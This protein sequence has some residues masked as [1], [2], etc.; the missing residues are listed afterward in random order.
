MVHSADSP[1]REPQKHA[2]RRRGRVLGTA[3]ALAVTAGAVSAGYAAFA[4]PEGRAP[5]AAPPRVRG[6]LVDFT[7][8]GG[9]LT[10]DTATL[11]ITGRTEDGAGVPVSD[12]AGGDLGEPGRVE[13]KG[14][15]DAWSA[16]WA[17]PKGLGVT[18]TGDGGRLRM[19]VRAQDGTTLDWPVS[20][21]G[22]GT[23]GRGAA[24]QVPRGEGLSV[25]VADPFWNSPDAGLAGTEAELATGS[26]TLPLWGYTTGG[27]GVSYLVPESVGTSLAFA[28]AGGRL[29][30]TARHEFSRREDTLDYTVTF[31]LTAASPV[32][33]AAD[34]RR[35]LREHGQS[36]TLKEKIAANPEVG[37]LLGAHHAYLWGGARSPEA[38]RRLRELGSTRAWLGYDADGS[39]MSAEAVAA[40]KR[41]GYVVGPYDTYANGQDPATADT[42]AAVWPGGV[43]PGHCVRTWKGDIKKGFGNRGC[44]LSSEAFARTEATGH[45]LAD[46]ARAVTGN[47]ANSVFLDV[48]A[49]GELF[50]DF[51]PDHPMTKKQDRANRMARMRTLADRYRFVLGSESAVSWSAPVL[52]FSHGS[53]TPAND[54]LWPFQKQAAWGAYHPQGAPGFFFRP[55]E[56]PAALA[57]SLYDPAYRVPLYQTA[58]HDSLISTERWE[59]PYDKFPAQKTDRALM[60]LLYNTPLNFVL[61]DGN[62]ES[63]GREMARLQRAFA[64]LHRAAGTEPM[65]DFRRLTPDRLVQRTVFGD[66]TLTVTANFGTAPYHGLP[67]GCADARLK[68]DPA[69][70]RLCPSGAGNQ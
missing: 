41:Q 12:A 27:H 45:H 61:G 20:G 18:A 28:S 36:R 63:T 13:V 9:T 46:R 58:L 51:S 33:P 19:T 31:A 30:A 60:S 17:Y 42:P 53:Q 49:A 70:R 29:H 66:G 24:L 14:T 34:Y 5:Q 55:V 8:A 52:A 56:L 62:L 3:L 2:R 25:P 35:W 15:R 54:T 22:P 32:A 10:V 59:M 1:R 11:R 6:A 26:L 23:G 67:P 47:G 69:P 40:A 4:G 48:D 16:S 7:V 37:K 38:V 39:P 57:T 44:Y 65:T 21:R 68:H 64:P 50:S 43:Y